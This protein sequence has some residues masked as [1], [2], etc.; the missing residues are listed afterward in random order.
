[1]EVRDE[2]GLGIFDQL[3]PEILAAWVEI[4]IVRLSDLLE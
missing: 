2:L 4:P 1:V 3:D